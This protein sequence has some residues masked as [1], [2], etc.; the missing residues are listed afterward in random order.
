MEFRVRN[1]ER[2]RKERRG[3]RRRRMARITV[4]MVS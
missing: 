3:L 1:G 4:Y 2:E